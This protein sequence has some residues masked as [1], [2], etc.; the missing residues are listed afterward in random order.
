MAEVDMCTYFA[1]L[2]MSNM[3]STEDLLLLMA[4]HTADKLIEEKPHEAFEKFD[5]DNFSNAQCRAL[6]QFDKD[7]LVMLSDLMALPDVYQAQN[8]IVWQP[9]EGTCILLRRLCYPGRLF[10]LA[11][12]FGCSIPN[13]SL[14]FNNML[15]DV[16]HRFSYLLN[17]VRQ[18]WMDHELY[19]HKITE[20][21]AVVNNIWGFVDGTLQ[22]VC[23]PGEDQRE[24]F[25]GHK[26]K[27]ALK[28]Q[29]IMLPNGLV[30]HSFGPFPGRRHDA[31]L[32]GVSGVDAQLSQI[33]ATDGQQLAI[34]G[35]QAYPR[36]PW[37]YTPF[38]GDNLT[39]EQ[40]EFNSAMSPLRTAVE[41]GF[42]KL[43]TYFVFVN[44]YANL[45][46]R[47]QPI[48]HYFQTAT[49]LANCHT[50]CYGSEVATY[51]NLNPPPTRC[52]LAVIR[53]SC[54]HLCVSCSCHCSFCDTHTQ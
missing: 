10:D 3:V 53:Y 24:Y 7:D 2:A 25:L 6:F 20:K 49:L 40:Q 13:C 33:F 37:L 39:H 47:L 41:W 51:F 8:G 28:F 52:L 43:T 38:G 22:H 34:Y 29:H 23:R 16:T 15:A 14:I 4:A 21:G 5:I 19:A 17:D 11:P 9:L 18:P 54:S 12:Y 48:G 27:H 42:A 32:Y 31:S 45:K 30:A 46:I 26:R 50:C 36:H 44:F 1:T 35:D